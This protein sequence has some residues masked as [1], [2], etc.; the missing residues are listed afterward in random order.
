MKASNKR[1]A[2]TINLLRGVLLI[3]AGI[4]ALFFP[5]TALRFALIAGGCLL[6]VDGVLGA[7]ASQNY[8]IESIW[9]FWLS[10]TRGVLAVLAGLALLF[11]PLL[12]T[13]LT[14]AF[15]STAI[16]IGAIAIGLIELF[17]LLRYRKDYPPV[18][19]TV[20]GAL[21]YVALGLLLLLL[22]MAG[23][24]LIMQIAGGL[25]AVF[26]LI[27]LVRSWS[28]SSQALGSRP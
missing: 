21:I 11:S 25:V 13:V 4:L 22:P 12:A 14:P 18:W 28:S 20:L 2:V 17:I 26:G 3:V 24:L 5:A 27:Q 19:S 7:I 23:A 15:L 6:V 10:V 1:L 16:G 9:P 8:G